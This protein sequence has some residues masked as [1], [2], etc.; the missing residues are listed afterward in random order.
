MR[1]LV[2]G[3]VFGV[4]V[5]G[6]ALAADHPGKAA[7]D[8][9]CKSCHSADGQGNPAIAKM[10]K[11]NLRP[12]GSKEVQAKSDAELTNDIIK[13][14]GKMKPVASLAAKEASAVVGF[15]RTLKQ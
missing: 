9:A 5:V 15:V 2:S 7:Y 11:V 8:K 10:M 4:I 12:L 3:V 14:T 6:V 1:L 13:G